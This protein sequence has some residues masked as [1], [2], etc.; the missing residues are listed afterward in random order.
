MARKMSKRESAREDMR[1]RIRLQGKSRETFKTYWYWCDKYWNFIEQRKPSAG[2]ES[3]EQ[4]AT[5]WLSSLRVAAKTQD[6]A[7][8]SI[9]YLYREVKNRPLVGVSAVRSKIPQRVRDVLDESE[10]ARLF[11]ELRGVNLMVALLI[12]AAGLRI[13]DA[14]S[15]RVKDLSFERC[16]VHVYDGKGMKDRHCQFPEVLHEVIRRQLDSSKVLWEWDKENNPNGVSLPGAFDRK[17]PRAANEWKWYYL[18]PSDH[19]SRDDEGRLKRHHRDASNVSREIKAAS[20]RA[21]IDKRITS[22]N[23]RHSYA[24]HSIE[25]GV[26]IHTLQMLLGHTDIR[27]TEGYLHASKEGATAAKSPISALAGLLANPKIAIE[28]RKDN[29][30][31]PPELRIFAG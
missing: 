20:E 12:Y 13:G 26:P 5:A 16:Q 17:S 4:A 25:H 8:Q 22:H 28:R 30:Q 11:T 24:T 29:E 31:E 15:L 23:L 19:L 2:W 27:T 14:I 7:L 10:V 9:C 1:E 6:L 21:G 3:A 18:F